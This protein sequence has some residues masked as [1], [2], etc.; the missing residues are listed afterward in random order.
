MLGA[1]LLIVW[2]YLFLQVSGLPCLTTV[3]ISNWNN[4]SS[5]W[6]TAPAGA[7]ICFER[8]MRGRVGGGLLKK[9]RRRRIEAEKRR[10]EK[11]YVNLFIHHPK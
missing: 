5:W 2:L 11:K 10:N 8:M 4:F 1:A 7:T 9:K 3:N 6:N